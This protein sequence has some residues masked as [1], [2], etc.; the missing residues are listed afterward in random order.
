MTHLLPTAALALIGLSA[1]AVPT[2]GPRVS[3]GDDMLVAPAGNMAGDALPSAEVLAFQ[4]ADARLGYADAEIGFDA[5]NCALYTGRA[6]GNAPYSERLLDEQG[7][8]ICT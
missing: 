1:C 8:P 2:V 7:R 6:P 3:Y 4:R 5:Q